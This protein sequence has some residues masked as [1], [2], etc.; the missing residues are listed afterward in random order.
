MHPQVATYTDQYLQALQ[1]HVI[2][3]VEY[4]ELVVYLQAYDFEWA[5]LRHEVKTTI[6]DRSAT[7][8][9]HIPY[10]YTTVAQ[11]LR[12]FI[13]CMRVTT[14]CGRMS[15]VE[16]V[17]HEAV[18]RCI[19][20][21]VVYRSNRGIIQTQ[22][23]TSQKVQQY[24]VGVE[25]RALPKHETDVS[26]THEQVLESPQPL[27]PSSAFMR[28]HDVARVRAIL[29]SRTPRSIVLIGEAGVGKSVIISEAASG[30]PNYAT[31]PPDLL[32]S[33]IA[34]D[35]QWQENVV[36][37]VKTLQQ[38]KQ[39]L[40]ISNLG[41]LFEVGQYEGNDVSIGAY[42]RPFLE[43][44]ELLMLTECRPDQ[45]AKL[46]RRHPEV[47]RHFEPIK[48]EALP[49]K[50]LRR[51][52][53]MIARRRFGIALTP[54]AVDEVIR[55]HRRYAPYS[56][57]PGR[58]VR[59]LESL[60]QAASEANTN[61]IETAY[62]QRTFCAETG[63]PLSIIDDDTEL[64]P[65][66]LQH[67]FGSRIFGQRA[68]VDKMCVLLPTIKSKLNPL[69]KPIASLLFVG[70]TGVGKTELAKA[71]TEF[72]FGSGE[73]LLR[74]DM[75]EYSD[76][77]AIE[78]LT[79][80]AQGGVLTSAVRRQ[81]FSVVL[82]DELEK[83]DPAFND[84]L[85][86]LL[87]EGRLTDGAYGAVDF[88][89]TIIIMTSNVG[90][91]RYEQRP[92]QLSKSDEGTRA[93]DHFRKAV[94][95]HFRPEIF[96]RIGSILPFVPLGAEQMTQLAE[97]NLAQL[98]DRSGFKQRQVSVEYTP[99]VVAWIARKGYQPAY[100]ARYMQRLLEREIAAPV[101][102]KINK[103]AYNT[104]LELSLSIQS[105]RVEVAVQHDRLEADLNF[106]EE[107]KKDLVAQATA[108]RHTLRKV[109]D[110]PSFL[111]LEALI[112]EGKRQ[113]DPDNRSE[114]ELQAFYN[115][116]QT[117]QQLEMA[118]LLVSTAAT[119]QA[120][121]ADYDRE[122]AMSVLGVGTFHQDM[123][124]RLSQ[125][126]HDFGELCMD[127][128]DLNYPSAGVATLH[129]SNAT[130]HEIEWYNALLDALSVRYSIR[131]LY[132]LGSE[133]QSPQTSPLP[134]DEQRKFYLE[135][136][137][138]TLQGRAAYLLLQPEEGVHRRQLTGGKYHYYRVE[139]I[140]GEYDYQEG[141]SPYATRKQLQRKPTPRRT[142]T[143][144]VLR[145][146]VYGLEYPNDSLQKTAAKL[147]DQLRHLCRQTVI[148]A[149][150]R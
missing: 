99:E 133:L 49:E 61:F 57:M 111:Q 121:A 122:L 127:C 40:V 28:E 69:G 114:A 14:F 17:A 106:E 78:R 134:V 71:L 98:L 36:Q 105:D 86:Q 73:R 29:E 136:V 68:A 113:S 5:T 146:Q 118:D 100:G 75:S 147:A 48:I 102:H 33:L 94:E 117:Q 95:S 90:A 8:I 132:R 11:G 87:D 85:L 52:L 60:K 44:R 30:V 123:M 23:Y 13:P 140:P 91:R 24:Q 37:M 145:D 142:I 58:A 130:E 76:P 19:A 56:A 72:M 150:E 131:Y 101:A 53:G 31:T 77:V 62:V 144:V 63:L 10:C 80:G 25:L 103:Y 112:A 46:Q 83:A 65:D 125:W 20:D 66:M 120:Q 104:P 119:L 43:R 1:R 74:F 97:R 12:V 96:N 141:I 15:Q 149:L 135:G 92:V 4:E 38:H 59:F 79:Q 82:F 138:Y 50:D 84:L 93:A 21:S 7:V 51:T 64:P 116:Y 143:P 45:W 35:K 54:N 115:D 32:R 16:R 88:C 47:T 39:W 18:V 26:D 6:A 148:A 9:L 109:L 3:M 108:N 110:G 55:L 67:Y 22:W 139:V 70:P 27:T 89:S 2:D 129:L 126:Q 34:G 137:T 81:P 41:G 107:L 124:Q 128:Y 42:M